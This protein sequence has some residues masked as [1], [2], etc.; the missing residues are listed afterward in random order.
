MT[1]TAFLLL[2]LLVFI[3]FMAVLFWATQ[4]TSHLEGHKQQNPADAEPGHN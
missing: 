3:T 4:T 2:V 1:N